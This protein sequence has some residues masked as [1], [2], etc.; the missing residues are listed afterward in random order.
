MVAY[1]GIGGIRSKCVIGL[2][3]EPIN[4][5]PTGI[6]RIVYNCVIIGIED[7]RSTSTVT[8]SLSLN[9]GIGY[10]EILSHAAGELIVQLV[11][12]GSSEGDLDLHE[13][14]SVIG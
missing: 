10:D 9:P 2:N 3:I 1:I 5:V 8:H 14:C 12:D 13:V 7:I 6:R 4:V 11:S